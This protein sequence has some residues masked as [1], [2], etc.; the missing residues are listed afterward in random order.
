MSKERPRDC[1]LPRLEFLWWAVEAM[2]TR[3]VAG[4]QG[5]VII[6]LLLILLFVIAFL[7]ISLLLLFCGSAARLCLLVAIVILLVLVLLL[8]CKVSVSLVEAR[9]DC[10]CGFVF[11]PPIGVGC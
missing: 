11:C 9:F 3:I 10:V 8:L 7:S 4:E 6:V 2:V 1:F 5:F